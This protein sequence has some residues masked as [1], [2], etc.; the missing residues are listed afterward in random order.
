MQELEAWLEVR[1][2]TGLSGSSQFDY[3]WDFKC[4]FIGVPERDLVLIGVPERNVV[5]SSSGV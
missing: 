1:H 3:L 2:V 5:C 4:H